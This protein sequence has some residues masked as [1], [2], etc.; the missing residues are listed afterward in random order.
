MP[1]SITHVEMDDVLSSIRRLVSEEGSKKPAP[2]AKPDNRFILTPAH[3]I[4]ASDDQVQAAVQEPNSELAEVL[5]AAAAVAKSTEN[6]VDPAEGSH[7]PEFEAMEQAWKSE[8]ARVAEARQDVK[9]ELSASPKP[10]TATPEPSLELRIAELEEAVGKD[11]GD[12]EPDGSEP[13]AGQPLK[14]HIFE[15]VDNSNST[16][17]AP[18]S[19]RPNDSVPVFSHSNQPHPKPYL[20]S[21]SIPPVAATDTSPEPEQTEPTAAPKQAEFS[22][23]RSTEMADEDDVFLDVEA[24]RTMITDVVRQ[25]LRG[26]LGESITKNVRRMMQ[27][28]I[29]N[30]VKQLKNKQD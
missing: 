9:D 7:T 29:S 20:L 24:L 25:E 27:Q 19:D 11:E 13:E 10:G 14:R 12:W 1:D 28:E 21:D 18:V 22:S 16:D 23:S 15:V 2:M 8:L 4:E 30:A 17:S 26:K 3:R 5:S 6:S